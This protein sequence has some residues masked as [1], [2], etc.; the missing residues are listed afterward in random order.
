MP[1]GLSLDRSTDSE[2]RCHVS[3]LPPVQRWIVLGLLAGL[4]L[5]S[6][7]TLWPVKYRCELWQFMVWAGVWLAHACLPSAW[8][9]MA[10]QPLTVRWPR[11]LGWTGALSLVS[12][13]AAGRGAWGEFEFIVVAIV[14]VVH[15]L[16][17][18]IVCRLFDW[19]IGLAGSDRG[20]MLQTPVQFSLRQ[21]LVWIAATAVLLALMKCIAFDE[22]TL[23]GQLLYLGLQTMLIYWPLEAVI[24][25]PPIIS[26]VGL[27]LARGDRIRFALWTIAYMPIVIA[28]CLYLGTSPFGRITWERTPL[29]AIFAVVFLGTLLGSL[30]VVRLCGYRLR[31]RKDDRLPTAAESLGTIGLTKQK[32]D[33][34]GLS[35]GVPPPAAAVE[36]RSVWRTPFPCLVAMMLLVWLGLSWPVWKQELGR[37]EVA[38]E[39]ELKEQW[40]AMGADVV[41][42]PGMGARVYFT[43]NQPVSEATL[44]KLRDFRSSPALGA[45]FLRATELTDE[46]MHYLGNQPTLQELD[47]SDNPITDAGLACLDGLSQLKTLDL[48]NTRITDAGL[49]HL[50]RCGSLEQLHLNGTPITDAGLAEL[51]SLTALRALT[52][53]NTRITDEGLKH[54]QAFGQLQRLALFGTAITD[55]GLSHLYSFNDLVELSLNDT[56]I[57]DAAMGEFKRA[58]PS[59][60]VHSNSSLGG[61][62]P[63][64]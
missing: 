51:K 54:V 47:L 37:R 34:A 61:P 25:L 11:A 50:A 33:Q 62:T 38:L 39:R 64:R 3:V 48:R 45:V 16:A 36:R 13:W 2:N 27:A 10:D 31:R 32:G 19:R 53:G 20:D 7:L 43:V 15:S 63:P 29:L 24:L 30:L 52:L 8:A 42:L 18:S 17:L 40:K 9:A 35:Q 59:C 4:L 22:T 5:F 57:T 55:E 21:L 6:T 60:T 23:Q 56:Q 28:V 26:C 41:V 58:R 12:L 1:A 46:Q 44:V 14:F 49:K